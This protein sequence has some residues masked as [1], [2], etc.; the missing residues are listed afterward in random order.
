MKHVLVTKILIETDIKGA[1][2]ATIK[3]TAK[4]TND[5]YISLNEIPKDARVRMNSALKVVFSTNY[6]GRTRLLWDK[7]LI[8]LEDE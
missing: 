4:I 8:P 3:K 5:S 6:D 2:P 7:E 1:H